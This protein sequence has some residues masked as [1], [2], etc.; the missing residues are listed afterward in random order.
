MAVTTPPSPR[1]TTRVGVLP[2]APRTPRSPTA[3]VL[4]LVAACAYA[5]FAHGAVGLPEEPRLQIGLALV[6][7]VAS[8]GWLL[9]G[10]LRLRAPALAWLGVALLALFAVWC[11]VT[12]LWSVAPD[13]TWAHI[14]RATTYTLVVVLAI[15]AGSSALRAIERVALGWLVVAVACAL[16]ALAGKVIPGVSFLGIDFN[17]TETVS[18]LRA[19]LE[20]WNALALVCV[21]AI[22]IALRLAADGTRRVATR[23]GGLSAL[24]VLLVCLA[25]TYSRGGILALVVA[26]AVMT[27]LGGLRL[28]VLAVM[29]I[30]LLFTIPVIGLAF[31]RPALK[32]VRVPLDERI[33]DG[34]VLGLVMAGC[35]LG[36]LIAAWGL[37]RLEELTTWT[38]ARTRNVWRALAVTAGLLACVYIGQAVTAEGGPRGVADR[39]WESFTKTSKDDV[40]DPARI[41]TANSGNRWVWWE[42]AAGAWSERPLHGWG[43]GSFPVTHKLFRQ[44][45]LGVVQPH[46]ISLQFLAETGLIGALLVLGGLGVLLFTALDR[47]RA[48]VPGRQRDIAVALYA[49]AVAWLVHSF[50]DW[51]WDIPGV[52]V[53]A[54]LF[55]G[56][57]IAIPREVAWSRLPTEPLERPLGPRGAALAA[58]CVVLG[59]AIVS[60]GLPALADSKADSAL[61][62]SDDAG[63]KEL[64]DATAEAELAARLDPTSVRPLLVSAAL[65]QN[66]DRLVDARRYLLQ[67][68]D[69]QPYSTA[70]WERLLRLALLTADRPG[71]QA[72]AKRLLELD[73]MGASARLLAARLALFSVPSATSPTATGTPLAPK[74][75]PA[76]PATPNAP[77]PGTAAGPAA[78]TGTGPAAGSQT[79]RQ[80][81]PPTGGATQAPG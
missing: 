51:H 65:A 8:V 29:S 7:V 26:I 39:A 16:Y 74:Y 61:V 33:P 43:A 77:A 57:L 67:A 14:N 71:A 52:T 53:P 80:L 45:E 60:A 48:M 24:F 1:V 30:A 62:V 81:V 63:A 44:Q 50:V 66:R 13:R 37:L 34:V 75:A 68:V 47:V 46:N 4:A 35:L 64:R 56:V 25:M 6:A 49:G 20:Y 79:P 15:A 9:S 10:T 21:L 5:V 12:M 42:E 76:A 3:L 27:A 54:L 73:P 70:A 23:L 59:L 31:N 40:S 55:V 69:R 28:R 36:L 2:A 38:E 22:P 18:R 17:H 78:G 41:S 72:A 32:G 58:A 19:P 11:G